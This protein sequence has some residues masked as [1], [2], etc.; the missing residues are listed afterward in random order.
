M[1]WVSV[2]NFETGEFEGVAIVNRD[3]PNAAADAAVL[4]TGNPH[5]MEAAVMTIPAGG[6]GVPGAAIGRL[7]AREELETHFAGVL[8]ELRVVLPPPAAPPTVH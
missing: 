1:Y 4:M 7:M 3:T 5:R 2:S 8:S 6:S